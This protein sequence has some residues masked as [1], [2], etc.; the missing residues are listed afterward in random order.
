MCYCPS[1][2]RTNQ[3]NPPVAKEETG[4]MPCPDDTLLYT[5]LYTLYPSLGSEYRSGVNYVH[6][7]CLH[8]GQLLHP[9]FVRLCKSCHAVL[10]VS[11]GILMTGGKC[12]LG[13]TSGGVV[14]YW[15]TLNRPSPNMAPEPAQPPCTHNSKQQQHFS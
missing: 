6:G 1:V 15:G 13:S 2:A 9:D 12:L 7:S 5:L 11:A 3:S 8:S 10:L 14:Y 4:R